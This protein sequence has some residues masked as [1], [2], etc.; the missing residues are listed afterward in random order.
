MAKTPNKATSKGR[1]GFQPGNAAAVGHGAPRGN[2]NGRGNLRHGL[3]AGQLP[4][5][6]KY[7]EYRLNDFRR[8]LE[9]AVMSARGEVSLVD[10]ACIQTCL[11]WERHA[12]LAQRWLV[13]AGD[14]LKPEQRLSFSREI[15]RASS[16][17]DKA[18][19]A[20]NLDARPDM[21]AV[22]DA[23]NSNGSKH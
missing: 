21:W 4:K 11:R 16:E 14:T 23:P 1:T 6:A 10:A 19:A 2:T 20:L 5:D 15:A 12:A 9:D 7:I 17:R 13:K 18:L 3:K 8:Q 22:I